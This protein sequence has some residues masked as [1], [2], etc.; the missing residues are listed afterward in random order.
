M[1]LDS[2]TP[3]LVA[4]LTGSKRQAREIV[5]LLRLGLQMEMMLS[6]KL[7]MV[8]IV[9]DGSGSVLNRAPA[10]AAPVPALVS[11]TGTPADIPFGGDFAEMTGL[12]AD[13]FAGAPIAY[14]D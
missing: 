13:Y 5:H 9:S 8:G 2:D 6:G 11:A 10:S 14:S 4:R 12:D 3:E 1:T 7:P